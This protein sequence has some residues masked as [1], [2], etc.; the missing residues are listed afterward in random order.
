[1]LLEQLRRSWYDLSPAYARVS[2]TKRGI[3][4]EASI[5]VEVFHLEV[6]PLRLHDCKDSETSHHE[7]DPVVLPLNLCGL[8]TSECPIRFR[9]AFR[10]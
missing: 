1:M 7:D 6:W 2:I 8:R 5:L 3:V 9:T 4:E 10:S